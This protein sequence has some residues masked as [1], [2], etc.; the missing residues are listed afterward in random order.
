MSDKSAYANDERVIATA[1]GYSVYASGKRHVIANYGWGWVIDEGP[2][3][4]DF[5][6][7]AADEAIHSLIGDPR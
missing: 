6:F 2:G 4:P 3:V 1:T 5:A 7:F